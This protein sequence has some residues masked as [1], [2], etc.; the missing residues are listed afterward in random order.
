MSWKTWKV[1]EIYYFIS[2]A[3]KVMEFEYRSWKV[4]E[5][6][7]KLIFPRTAKQEIPQRND[8]F[9]IILKTTS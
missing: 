5:N 3:W 6:D 1:M 7:F 8:R 9:N 2:Q 4:M